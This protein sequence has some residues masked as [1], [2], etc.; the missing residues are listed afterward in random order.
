M[1]L[2]A[3][4]HRRPE[5]SVEPSGGMDAIEIEISGCR[6]DAARARRWLGIAC[7]FVRIPVVLDGR[8]QRR[9][10]DS[11]CFRVRIDQPIPATLALGVGLETPRLWLLRHGVVV[12]RVSVAGRPAFEGAVELEGVV[13]GRASAAKIREAVLPSIG[14]LVER[15]VRST[16]R[17]VPRMDS[18]R[19]E[20]RRRIRICLLEAFRQNLERPAIEDAPM[21]GLV[22]GGKTRWISL[23]TLRRRPGT[24]PPVVDHGD[25]AGFQ[26][27]PHLVLDP[28]ER[29]RVAEAIGTVLRAAIRRRIPLRERWRA[30]GREMLEGL[31]FFCGPPPVPR[32]KLRADERAVLLALE[33][34]LTDD[35]R[36]VVVTMCRGSGRPRRWGRRLI[37]PRRGRLTRAGVAA[38][39]GDSETV[40]L[41]AVAVR[42]RRW[43]VDSSVRTRWSMEKS[44]W[45]I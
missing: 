19:E 35:G 12:S 30:V 4:R 36:P 40:Y 9:D 31:R 1:R 26:A 7:R 11:G 15:A 42:S 3:G 10:L 16:V 29:E 2:G 44:G 17:V 21:L 24:P 28:A 34:C 22:E 39:T 27:G 8:D 14:P 5:V 33:G 41:V 18:I 23:E 45:M 38:L 20:C 6:F 13:A 32:G 43:A 25:R 37:L